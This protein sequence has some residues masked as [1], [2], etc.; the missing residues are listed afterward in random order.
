[1]KHNRHKDKQDQN[2]STQYTNMGVSE[3]IDSVVI[4]EPEPMNKVDATNAIAS[5]KQHPESLMR[6]CYELKERNGYEALGYKSF[7]LCIET[8]L[9]GEINYEE[10]RKQFQA[11]KVHQNV[12][13][14]LAMGSIDA[15]ILRPL[16]KLQKITRRLIWLSALKKK[17]DN[18]LLITKKDI[19]S[20]I[21]KFNYEKPKSTVKSIKNKKDRVINIRS[22]K[23][24]LKQDITLADKL[25]IKRP[26]KEASFNNKSSNGSVI[27]LEPEFFKKMKVEK[28]CSQFSRRPKRNQSQNQ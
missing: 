12:C 27:K 5:I 20:I 1:M 3:A 16:Y 6:M 14:E 17:C 13:P 26:L 8:E 24:P 10:A 23:T 11:G 19:K 21:E 28:T 22:P 9:E 4:R 15:S 2:Y 25:R 18:P 7:R